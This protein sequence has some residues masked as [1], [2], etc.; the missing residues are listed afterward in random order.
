MATLIILNENLTEAQKQYL[1][2]AFEEREKSNDWK[3]DAKSY[4]KFARN[5]E[6][7]KTHIQLDRMFDINIPLTNFKIEL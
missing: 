6:E 3:H 4:S 7:V 2:I 5:I 1:Q